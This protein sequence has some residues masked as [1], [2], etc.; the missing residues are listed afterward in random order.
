[1]TSHPLKDDPSAGDLG[2]DLND[3]MT[4]SPH[5][6]VTGL[7]YALRIGSDFPGQVVAD[8]VWSSTDFHNWP[9]EG[10]QGSPYR[11]VDGTVV[12]SVFVAI[13]EYPDPEPGTF[14]DPE[15]YRTYMLEAAIPWTYLGGYSG[16]IG[17]HLTS[18][19]GNDSINIDPH[20]TQ[21][22]PAPG[23]LALGSLGL[24][25]VGWLRRRRGLLR[26]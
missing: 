3:D 14:S 23:A 26:D 11:A 7:E 24:S 15:D 10:W 8:P 20:T 13:E 9:G 22:I 18:Q 2:I 12:G 16:A 21:Q 25:L 17:L 5:G 4:I 19:C 1:V 6:I